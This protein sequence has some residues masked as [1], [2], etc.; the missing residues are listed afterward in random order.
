M[1]DAVSIAM[2]GVAMAALAWVFCYGA[3]KIASHKLHR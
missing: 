3:A 1:N 2:N